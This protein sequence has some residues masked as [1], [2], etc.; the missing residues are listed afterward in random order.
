MKV[1]DSHPKLAREGW[2]YVALSLVAAVMT[3]A[4]FPFYIAVVFW[5]IAAFVLQFFRDPY[6]RRRPMVRLYSLVWLMIPI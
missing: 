4:V 1:I 5:V 2:F 6:P 3:T